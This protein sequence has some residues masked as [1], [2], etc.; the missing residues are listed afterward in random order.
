MAIREI[1]K[2]PDPRLREVSKP[3]PAL[4]EAVQALI[5]DM[6]DTMYDADGL[7]LAA[8]QVGVPLRIFVADMSRGE[9]ERAPLVFVNPEIT[10][11]S[12]LPN[13]HE[14][15][16]LSIPEVVDTVSRPAEVKIRYLDR[17]GTQQELH[18]TGLLATCVQH[19]LDHL[20]GVLFIDYLSRLK[21]DRIVKKFTKAKRLEQA[22]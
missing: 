7:G 16:C 6:L 15:G 11:R 13:E 22:E 17:H 12:E 2:L 5:D 8:I 3:V 21:R 14:E 20:N 1:I 4:D 18:C 19:E 9:G 10:W